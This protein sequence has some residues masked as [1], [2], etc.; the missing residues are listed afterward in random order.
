MVMTAVV[1]ESTTNPAGDDG[2]TRLPSLDFWSDLGGDRRSCGG[3]DPGRGLDRRF[4]AIL[5]GGKGRDR[6]EIR[7]SRRRSRVARRGA[8]GCLGGGASS[9]YWGA[10]SLTRTSSWP[11]GPGRCG[12]LRWDV[13][14]TASRDTLDAYLVA[15]R[16]FVPPKAEW[17]IAA[18]ISVVIGLRPGSTAAWQC[19]ARRRRSI[20]R[21]T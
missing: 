14:P 6:L 13:A 19:T 4:Q 18:V 21:P 20:S 2:C 11:A 1:A 17:R 12:R 3:G 8:P 9:M 5:H 10:G 16:P 15:C 7:L